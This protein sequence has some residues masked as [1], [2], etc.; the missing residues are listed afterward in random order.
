ME[1]VKLAF[2][3]QQNPNATPDQI[4]EAS[5]WLEH[6]Q[7]TQ[8]AWT[9]ADQILALPIEASA[10]AAMIFAAQTLR[11][12]I[13]YDWNELPAPAH[14]SLRGSLLN[15]VLRFGQVWSM[16]HCLSA[17]AL[18]DRC[19]CLCPA[20]LVR[21]ADRSVLLQG[22]MPVLTQLCLS[23]GILALHMDS[24]QTV[25]NDLVQSLT[26]PPDQAAQKLP[27]LLELLTVLPEE[28]ENYKV[29][30]LPARR[31]QFRQMLRAAGPQVLQLLVAVHGQC[32]M[33]A[34]MMQRMLKCLTSW[35][36]HVP[37]PS[38]ELARS[39]ILGYSFSALAS[40]DLFDV[41]ADFLV[42]AVHFS[43]DHEQHQ[44]LITA[45]VPQVHR[46]WG[47]GWVGE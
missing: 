9:V 42:E 47:W 5:V 2:Q 18:L 44:E 24:W 4:K 38:N 20:A 16:L 15:H 41:A 23:V 35:L 45:I 8:E 3:A 10:H 14:E 29:G 13:Q 43:Q 1:Q 31:E 6:F 19:K 25:V 46:E 40:P 26:T 32:Q 21:K 37:M 28:A 33:Q 36:R 30:V 7:G 11:T 17:V 34:D 39:P 12:K 27:C 22:P